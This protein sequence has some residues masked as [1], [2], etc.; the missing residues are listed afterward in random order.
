[1]FA[2]EK[3]ITSPTNAPFVPTFPSYVAA[4]PLILGPLLM[5]TGV[6]FAY[7]TLCAFL[8]FLFLNGRIRLL[9][10]ADSS[11]GIS[12]ATLSIRALAG[13]PIV[14]VMAIPAFLG[15]YMVENLPGWASTTIPKPEFFKPGLGEMRTWQSWLEKGA[16]IAGLFLVIQAAWLIVR[17]L[18]SKGSAIRPSVLSR[19]WPKA[20]PMNRWFIPIYWGRWIRSYD[21]SREAQT[22][23]Q[24]DLYVNEKRLVIWTTS[25]GARSVELRCPCGCGRLVTL[26]LQRGGYQKFWNLTAHEDETVSLHPPIVVDGCKTCFV[27]ERNVPMWSSRPSD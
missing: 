3:T 27:V 9:G 1:M 19:W 4:H 24:R 18:A 13:L 21:D 10:L 16:L 17:W 15:G 23:E 25:A 14:V 26:N 7:S 20:R 2:A 8:G 12:V 22:D 5:L 6:C 11:D